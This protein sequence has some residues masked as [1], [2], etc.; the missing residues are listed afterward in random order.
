MT[1]PIILS[2]AEPIFLKTTKEINALW[3]GTLEVKKD[4]YL[5]T[6]SYLEFDDEY[7]VV[8]RIRKKMISGLVTFLCTIEH[9]MCELNNKSVAAFETTTSPQVLLTTLLSGT[10][11]T[12]GIVGVTGNK[13]VRSKKRI[14]VLRSL[15]LMAA[16]WNGEFDFHSKTR[17]V[18]FKSEIGTVTEQ[19]IRYDKNTDYIV[20]EED[21]TELVTRLYIYG[22]D[23]ITCQSVNPTGLEYIDSANIGLYHEPIEDTVYTTIADVTN[24]YNYGLAYLDLYDDEIFRYEINIADMTVFRIWSTEGI[25][26]G[27]TAK[28]QNTDLNLNIAV[29]VK[30]IIKDFIDPNQSIIELD[31]V[32]DNLA[33]RLANWYDKLT[34]IA[35][36]DDEPGYTDPGNTPGGD[37]DPY[38]NPIPVSGLYEITTVGNLRW[39]GVRKVIQDSKG[40]FHACWE[41]ANDVVTYGRSVDGGRTWVNTH[42]GIPYDIYTTF[43]EPAICLGNEDEIYITCAS[44]GTGL[45]AFGVILLYISTDSGNS[46]ANPIQIP[47]GNYLVRWMGQ[48][49]IAVDSAGDICVVGMVTRDWGH[50]YFVKS[51][52]NGASWTTE[53]EIPSPDIIYLTSKFSYAISESGVHHFAFTILKNG[54]S[55]IYTCNSVNGGATWQHLRTLQIGGTH[56]YI[57][58]GQLDYDLYCVWIYN[59]RV[60]YSKCVGTTWTTPIAI[61]DDT[62]WVSSATISLDNN[63]N[64]YVVYTQL[65]GSAKYQVKLKV[66]KNGAWGAESVRTTTETNKTYVHLVHA[67]Y[68]IIS[69][70]RPCVMVGGFAVIYNDENA[71]KF[72]VNA[73]QIF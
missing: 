62:G 28:V 46:W 8:R 24:L 69:G 68:P 61:S 22:D 16:E 10:G 48:S 6:Q 42:I 31:N 73:E 32:H 37:T 64:I 15:W 36:Y 17:T 7:W 21:A 5:K 63:D 18:D 55:T 12:V 26:L 1:E 67:R 56:P 53:V 44:S 71:I 59:Q 66:F 50:A 72:W 14:S 58:I 49:N 2:I 70:L 41:G 43:D 20:R 51:S 45:A 11:W 38:E 29:R 39:A 34:E 40:W 30:K 47:F 4:D 9:N 35:P 52:N 23:D 13:R 33:R 27:D 54:V 60:Y 19:P 65:T 25:H 57:A 3:Y